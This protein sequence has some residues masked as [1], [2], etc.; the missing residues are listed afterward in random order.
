M[1]AEELYRAMCDFALAHGYRRRSVDEGGWWDH[2]ENDS[3]SDV[4]LGELVEEELRRQGIDLRKQLP[5]VIVQDEPG[6]LGG[7]GTPL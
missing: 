4:T 6:R 1:T 5:V 7:E 3:L 2:E